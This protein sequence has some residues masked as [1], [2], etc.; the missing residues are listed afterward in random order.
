LASATGGLGYACRYADGSPIAR[1]HLE[2]VLDVI[3]RHAVSF[4][5]RC[6]DVLLL[7]N[8]R[9]AHG[10]APYRGRREILVAMA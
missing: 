9:V 10:R 7:D 8:L 4:D 3:E 6:G 1:E 2:H 5:W